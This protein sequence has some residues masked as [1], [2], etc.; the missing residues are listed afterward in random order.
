VSQGGGLEV[1]DSTL[2]YEP[3]AVTDEATVVATYEP[4]GGS[5]QGYESEA[6]LEAKFITM[7]AQQAYERLHIASAA[8]LEANLRRQLELLNNV[9]FTDDEWRWFFAKKV[10]SKN[11]GI[12]E[13][14][15]RIQ[16]DPIQV[17]SRD[18]GTSKNIKLIDK[19]NIHANRLQ[20]IS[21]YETVGE[22]AGTTRTHRYDVTI[23]VNGLP[24][25]HVEL[26][27]RGVPLKEAFNQI[28]RYQRESFWADA[29]LFEYVQLF[30]ISNGTHTKY[31]ANTTRARKVAES[32]GGMRRRKQTS[33]SFEFTSWWT[34]AENHRIGDLTAF[35]RTFFAKQTLL[36]V[37]TKYCVFDVSR[38]LLVMRPYQIVAAERILRRV[39]SSA[40]TTG[41]KAGGY[42]WHTTGSGKTLT[43]FKTAQLASKMEGVDKVLF[44][45]DR[46]DLD[47]QT[48]LEYNRFEKDSVNGSRSTAE[49][50]RQLQDQNAS[51]IVT[52]IQKLS[53][54]IEQNKGHEITESHV[55]LIFDECHRSQ[56]GDMG[57]AVRK[58]FR[59][60]HLF[61][62]TG[63]P[64]FPQNAGGATKD[65][66]EKIFGDRLHSYTIL[67]AIN[68]GNVL[69]FRVSYQNTVRA[70]DDVEDKQVAG[71][72]TEE[73]LRHPERIRKIVAYIL[74]HFDTKT[75]R[76]QGYSLGEKRV[77]G[78]NS[79]LATASIPA[80]KIYYDE[81]A[82]QQTG[83]AVADPSYQ[84]LKI[85]TI[86]SY[87]VNEDEEAGGI[88][89][90]EAMDA[91]Q[92]DASSRD[93][94]ERSI[95]DYNAAF[96]TT[97]DTSAA[98]FENYYKDLARRV[99]DREVDLVIVVNMFLTGF[100]AT[101]LNTLWVDKNL[102]SH[103]LIQA[104]SRTNRILNS[105]KAYGNIVCFRN[106]EKA[107]D[108]ALVLFGNSEANGVV[109]L[110]PYTYYHAEYVSLVEQL[111]AQCPPGTEPFGEAQEK[112]FVVL[113]SRILRLRNIL[114]SFDEFAHDES[115]PPRQ[116]QNYTSVYNALWERRR[117]RN[118]GE[119]ES[120][121]DDVVF[122]I[123][124]I[125]QVEV[126]FDYILMLVQRWRDEGQANIGEDGRMP[127]RAI[128]DAIDASPSLRNKKDLIMDFVDSMSVTGEV[129]DDW[130]VFVTQRREAEL[131][132]IIDAERLRP[133]QTKS[134]IEA[135]FRDGAIATN[136][137]AITQVLPPVSRF[138]KDNNLGA[139]KERVIA[140]LTEYF[141]R[142]SKL[143]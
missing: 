28:N 123:E 115:L 125:K 50:K 35:T 7:L 80:L 9:V 41:P 68:D 88:L 45:V 71:I 86:F 81:F 103:G 79:M 139:K 6:E 67:D 33:N 23:L 141:E 143:A 73:V 116:L 122:E 126:N 63:T 117:R 92:L 1:P 38:T 21:Q 119:K 57:T 140:K 89:D 69:P 15:A 83:R 99:K 107:V 12:V 101:T 135:A 56:F 64:I 39:V 20:L 134:F 106:L 31:Y 87:A 132:E 27:R 52:T 96:G 54:F 113:F 137:T 131:A 17:L 55:V 93:F 98:K 58:A 109:L 47:Y 66:T 22:S 72:D 136:G 95:S 84:P 111:Q 112:A 105:V 42:I 133:E 75:M 14:T 46:K 53:R 8:D 82:R 100:D 3:I 13:K 11:E 76:T 108:D 49:L 61:G 43:S 32:E 10:A 70:T 51:I 36:N 142:F 78:F 77:R 124:L 110:K 5:D 59:R 74:D 65:T 104:F 29:G 40:K 26:K 129:N 37:L 128:E 4:D 34:D 114:T 24:L 48:M 62:F 44:V 85:A 130:R 138:A 97:Y 2:R 91:D 94:L 120:I 18:D 121:L 19:S 60:S 127:L 102:K 118:S 25:V 30:V 90:D 16:E